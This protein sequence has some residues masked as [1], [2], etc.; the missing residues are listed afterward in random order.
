MTTSPFALRG[1]VEAFYG[2]FYTAPERDDLIRFL[3]QHGFNFYLYGP[4]NDRQ[5][6]ARWRE[7][8]PDKIMR[9][10]AQTL[11]VARAAGVAFCYALSPG[12]DVI[13]ASDDELDIITGKFRAFYE[14]GARD[15][16]L[17]LD[18][19]DNG[20]QHEADRQRYRTYAEAHVDLCNR[21]YAGLRALDP[22]MRFSMCPTDYHGSAPFT[23]YLAE[24]GA[25]L[26]PEIDIFYTGPD[27]CAPAISAADAAAF[28]QVARRKPL[29]WDNYPVN[30]LSR[31]D[32]LQIG[33]VRQRAADLH[34]A[35]RGLLVN[36][37]IQAE[38][39][40]IPLLTFADYVRQPESYQPEDSWLR[41]LEVV[42]GVESAGALRLFA[43]N[44]LSSIFSTPEAPRLERLAAAALTAV[45]AGD[46]DGPDVTALEAYL[47]ELDEAAYHLK[48]RMDN[49]ALRN[50]LIPWIEKLESWVWMARFALQVLRALES[51]Q[52]TRR[53]LY[54]LKE[55]CASAGHNTKRIGG[56]CIQPL[57]DYALA[58]V[59]QQETA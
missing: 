10:F 55:S 42:G 25:G 16:S 23:A 14:I 49:L 5:H 24:L 12:I 17:L 15:F 20:F 38:A 13:Y 37:M 27:V 9:Q 30:D 43:E 48:F 26:H 34:T 33:P 19:L 1:V 47:A 18:D 51:G 40:K 56:N 52:P 29:I 58:Q 11:Q 32:L 35:V 53:P 59:Q 45:T 31:A 39:S 22:Q 3:G 54:R 7:P 6:R 8:Y 46:L 28:A 50:N 36:P 57:A 21:A 2:V 4:K 44:S 41:A